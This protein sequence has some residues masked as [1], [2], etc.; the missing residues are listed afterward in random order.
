MSTRILALLAH[1]ALEKS[2]VNRRLLEAI[3]GMDGVTINDLYEAYP[4]FDID[5]LREQQ[6][7]VDHDLIVFQHPSYW[8]RTPAM[9][10]QWE[11]LA[12]VHDPVA[13]RDP[14]WDDESLREEFGSE[15]AEQ[16]D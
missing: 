5:V 11:D 16:R 4:D 15:Q 3:R 9:V 6:Q 8:Y 10:K 2:R 7:L 14:G 12:D 13:T 1:P